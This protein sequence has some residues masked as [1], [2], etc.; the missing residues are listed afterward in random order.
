MGKVFKLKQPFLGSLSKAFKELNFGER[1]K[2]GEKIAIKLHFGEY[3]N[4]FGIRPQLIERVADEVKKLGA[5]PFAVDSITLYQGS[6][7]T[8]KKHLETARKNGFVPE[9]IGCP[10]V[11]G[12]KGKKVS[13]KILKEFEVINEIAEADG[14]VVVSHVKGHECSGLGA[15][16]KNL[17]MGG[18]TNKS[19]R[20]IHLAGVPVIDYKKCISCGECFEVCGR[21]GLTKKDGKIIVT[22]SEF[23]GCGKCFRACS[24][25]ALK[26]KIAPFNH[27]LTDG[28]RA[29]LQTFGNEKVLFVN[30]V[31]AVTALC[32]CYANPG[33]PL[34]KDIGI[35]VS[36]DIVSIDNASFKLVNKEFGK[37]FSKAMDYNSA[38]QQ[39]DAGEKLGLGKREYELIGVK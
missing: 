4:L 1:F 13:G 22:E 29:V 21:D 38:F 39:I 23:C 2:K 28:A 26:E 19:K 17:G 32:D 27:A 5:K 18:L 15:S 24:Q 36:D 14:M 8:A 11:I 30:V 34:M 33:M 25:G 9:S 12:E 35:L 20:N 7:G 3:E 37:D 16:I 31:L 10:V 6:R